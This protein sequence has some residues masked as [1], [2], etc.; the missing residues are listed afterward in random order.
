MSHKTVFN[1]LLYSDLPPEELSL[2]R[3]HHEAAG[4][5]GAGIDTTK[6]ALSQASFHIIN[7]EKIFQRLRQELTEAF[8]DL[9]KPPTLLELEKLPYLSAIIQEG[10]DIL[11]DFCSEY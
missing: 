10:K 1:E 8:P 4:I 7:N 11:F 9:S 5:T 3:I 2:D 6:T